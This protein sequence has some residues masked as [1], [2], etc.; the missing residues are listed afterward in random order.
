MRVALAVVLCSAVP[1]VAPAQRLE[2][3]RSGVG[4]TSS[5]TT[6]FDRVRAEAVRDIQD[7]TRPD[8]RRHT[9]YGALGGAAL[10]GVY[11]ALPTEADAARSERVLVLPAAVLTGAAVGFVVGLVRRAF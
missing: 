9:L 5:A 6:F 7:G 10:W 3:L 1:G 11:F 4:S 8:L 2:A